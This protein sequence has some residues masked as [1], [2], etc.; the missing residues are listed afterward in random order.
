MPP[1]PPSH[2]YYLAFGLCE[3]GHENEAPHELQELCRVQY[4]RSV[5]L[6]VIRQ[7]QADFKGNPKYAMKRAL[8]TPNRSKVC[9]A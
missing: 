4:G 7:A 5:P 8:K 3:A 2:V 6:E 1:D 9:N